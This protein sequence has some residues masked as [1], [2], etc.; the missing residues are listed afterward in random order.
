MTGKESGK[1]GL[2]KREKGKVG[3]NLS[4][5]S[6]LDF[7]DRSPCRFGFVDFRLRSADVLYIYSMFGNKSATN[8]SKWSIV[9]TCRQLLHGHTQT[10]RTGGRNLR[11]C[12]DV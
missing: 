3:G 11:S 7:S 8:E 12:C 4:P 6:I 9:Y 2:I 5:I 1:M 10:H